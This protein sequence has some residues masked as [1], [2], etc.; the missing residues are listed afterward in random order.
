MSAA[1]D[2]TMRGFETYRRL[3]PWRVCLAILLV[4]G[5]SAGSVFGVKWWRAAQPVTSSKPWFAS[6][7][8]VT[9]TP[10]F[11]FEQMGTTSNR[12]AVLSFIVALPASSCTPAWGGAYTMDQASGSLDLD[13]RIARLQQQNGSVAVSFGGQNNQELAVTCTDPT[14]LLGA[15]QSVVDRYNIDTIDLDLEGAGLTNTAAGERRAAAITKLQAD[16]R[17]SGKQLAVW[18]T[19]PAT[20]QG[21]SEAGTDAVSQLLSK[22]VDLAGVNVMTMDYGSSLTGGQNMLT[23]S[24]SALIQAQRQLGILYQRAGIHLNDATLW[25]KIGATPMIGQNDDAG[26]VFTMDDAKGLNQFALSHGVGRLSMWSANRDI[27]CGS[28]YVDL[29]VVSDSCSGVN[30]GKGSFAQLLSAG[31]K[32]DISLSAGLVTTSN[33]TSTKQTPDNPATSPYQIWSPEGAY[34]EGTKVVWHHNVYQAKWWTQG[35]VPDSPV[36]QS[37]QTP[38]DLIGPVLPGEKPIPQPTLPAGTYADWSGTATYNTGQRVLFNGVPYQAK[39]W[40][41]GDSPAASTSDANDSP[42]TPLT[43]TQINAIESGTAPGS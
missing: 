34:L 18:V 38:W 3:S 8:D 12:D 39:W 37:W 23:G 36:L 24:E 16:R 28:N 22:G 4:A 43:Q 17:A 40:N 13:R 27:T 32:G 11:A 9:A 7:V 1:T 30:E 2:V 41:Q 5:I 42:W 35:D 19:L 14:E 33:A 21:L 6:Y 15:Y 10:S 25:S 31:F 20:P 29:K 26:E